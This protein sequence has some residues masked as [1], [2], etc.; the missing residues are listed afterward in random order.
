MKK[1]HCPSP[2]K[3]LHREKH[4]QKIPARYDT[5]VRTSSF[6]PC[7]SLKIRVSD[8]SNTSPWYMRKVPLCSVLNGS[9]S[10][11]LKSTVQIPVSQAGFVTVGTMETGS[12]A[13]NRRW[14]VLQGHLMKYWNYPCE[15]DTCD[16][17]QIIDLKYCPAPV[18]DIVD[19]SLCARP[20]TLLVESYSAPK[21]K[22]SNIFSLERY[23]FSADNSSD[24]HDWEAQ[25]NIAVRALR[26]WNARF[27]N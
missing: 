18:I 23:F 27:V 4:T 21:T 24:L 22:E 8:L 14:C 25:F 1:S 13:W 17:L 9:I 10:M 6:K 3:F 19:R 12:L 2:K 16:P 11:T 15:E 5:G 7:G 26:T 20:R